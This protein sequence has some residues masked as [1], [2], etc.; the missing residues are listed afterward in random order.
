[1]TEIGKVCDVCCDA[2]T[3]DIVVVKSIVKG[4]INGFVLLHKGHNCHCD[5]DQRISIR[6]SSA[7]LDLDSMLSKR[8]LVLRLCFIATCAK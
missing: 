4:V 3:R 5:H 6:F 2:A 1:M 8:L 7:V